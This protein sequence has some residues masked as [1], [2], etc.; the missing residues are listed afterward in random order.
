VLKPYL[1]R[2]ANDCCFSPVESEGQRREA[3]HATRTTPLTY[4]NRPG[5]S[6]T[7]HA[8]SRIGEEFTE[9]NYNQAIRRA[10]EKAFGMPQNLRRASTKLSAEEKKEAS[11]WRAKHCWSPNQLRHSAATRIR[12]EF[13]LEAAQVVL[14]HGEM[15]TTEIYAEQ[16]ETLAAEVMRKIG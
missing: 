13:G 1:L 8:K 12:K 15:N 16:D 10:C 6:R 2:D 14:G 11:A 3:Q 4:G 7:V 9:G 5:F